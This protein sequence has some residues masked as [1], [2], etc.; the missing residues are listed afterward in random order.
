MLCGDELMNSKRKVLE[1]SSV[2]IHS[3]ANSFCFVR[4]PVAWYLPKRRGIFECNT[5]LMFHLLQVFLLVVSQLISCAFYDKRE[6]FLCACEI[7]VHPTLFCRERSLAYKLKSYRII[8]P[9]ERS[10]LA[11]SESNPLQRIAIRSTV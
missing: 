8:H 4:C 1:R 2:A 9:A 7:S 3:L 10:S 6:I 5:L 11:W